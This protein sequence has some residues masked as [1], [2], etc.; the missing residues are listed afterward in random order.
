MD[1]KLKDPA[2]WVAIKAR[3]MPYTTEYNLLHTMISQLNQEQ[4][5][6]IS[7]TDILSIQKVMTN[8]PIWL[9]YCSNNTVKENIM[10]HSKIDM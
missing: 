7:A 9:I 4:E 8:D 10:K 3:G 1:D 2:L 6:K 5:N